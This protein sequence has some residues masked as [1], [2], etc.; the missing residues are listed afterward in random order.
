MGGEG[1]PSQSFFSPS[2][3]REGLGETPLLWE[4][5]CHEEHP[6]EADNRPGAVWS[7]PSVRSE[8]VMPNVKVRSY[9]ILPEL[10]FMDPF[11]LN[12]FNN[13]KNVQNTE[14]PPAIFSA[15]TQGLPSAEAEPNH[16]FQIIVSYIEPLFAW[17][18]C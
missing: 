15:Q 17:T 9:R 11:E 3:T 10:S 1:D 4:S 5:L 18:F 6:A 13:K 14:V 12:L 8:L 16:N 7:G 2:T